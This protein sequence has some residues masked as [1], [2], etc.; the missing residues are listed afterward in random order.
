MTTVDLKSLA[1]SG[2]HT[3]DLVFS[4]EGKP[5]YNLVSAYNVPWTDVPEEELGPLSVD[6]A[7]DRTEL[8]VDETVTANVSVTNNTDGP[9]NMA[10]VTLGLPPGFEVERDDFAQYLEAGTLSKF[11]ITGKQVILYISEIAAGSTANY[12]Y[13]LRAT[14]PIKAS[15]GGGSVYPY[16]QPD[17]KRVVAEQQIS[18]LEQQ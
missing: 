9:Q 16:Y 15:D 12:A 6:I 1:T 3:V 10:L 18:V 4:G 2:S 13:R 7:Y 8:A 5:S 17:K 14:M 11:E